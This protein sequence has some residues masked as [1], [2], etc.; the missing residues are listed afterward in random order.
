MID[1]LRILTAG[2]VDDG[3]STLIGRLMYDRDLVF[4][5]HLEALR[6]ASAKKGAPKGEIDF[7]LLCDG[8]KAEREQGITIDVAYRYLATDKRKFIIADCPGHEQYTR[9]MATG[10][11]TAE[12]AIILVDAENG[13]LPQTKRHSFIATLLGI[14]H[15]VIAINKMD[16]VNYSRETF[17]TIRTEYANFAA[18][19]EV[20][21]VH[22]I[23]MSALKGDNVVHRSSAMDWYEGDPLLSYLESVHIA[24]D[25]NF[26]DFRMP[27]Q[28]VIRKNRSRAYAGM[29]LSGT[30]HPGEEIVV[31]PSGQK[32]NVKAIRAFDGDMQEAFPPLSIA[33]EIEDNIDISRG[34]VF[35]RSN[36]LP[37]IGCDVEAMVVWMDHA[38]LKEEAQ[39]MA[40]HGSSYVPCS[41]ES[42]RYK[43][44]INTLKR[45]DS[46][47]L[48]INEIGRVA[49][50]FNRPITFD[51]YSRN[52]ST[53]GLILIDK[54][55]NLTVG[56]GMIMDRLTI[57]QH[58]LRPL[59]GN[60]KSSGFCIWLTGLSGSG[61]T[62]IAKAIER[63]LVSLGI[64]CERLDG[65]VLREGLCND[66]GFSKED[67]AINIGRS[68]F[69]AK[70][71]ARNNVAVIASFISPYKEIREKG[72]KEIHNFVE[73]YVKC[74]IEECEKRDPKGLYKKARTGKIDQFTGI[75]DPY[76]EP[77]EPD[78]ILRTDETPIER[79]VDLLYEYLVEHGLLIL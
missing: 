23:P 4:E 55:S 38:P 58:K 10:A 22:F 13:V 57:D 66:L 9:N 46:N 3:K 51:S 30:I 42:I 34:D 33:L 20:N 78:L 49:I 68:M 17:N 32:T 7:S 37:D 27:V 54:I 48:E 40:K 41:I 43:Y 24:S 77:S 19:L 75:D 18:K 53:G 76:E 2:S 1:I 29:V 5:D 74:P 6:K 14:R 47:S 21:D 25:R 63:E 16:L 73:V 45:I 35:V 56:A 11:S 61:K 72:K 28:Y 50:S 12:L 8:L 71:L 62:T 60:L 65:D 69:V 44:D 64:K 36:N 70:L 26:I 39:Y 67:R 79:C 52:R 31:L 59:H 15:L